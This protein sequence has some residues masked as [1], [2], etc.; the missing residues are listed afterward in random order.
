MVTKALRVMPAT[1]FS[2]IVQMTID[3]L[4]SRHSRRSYE[5]ALYDFLNWYASVQPD[6]LT[7]ATI[8]RYLAYMRDDQ[9]MAPPYINLRLVAIRRLVR[10][11][12]MN[13]LL[14]DATA[15]AIERIH[16]V[17]QEGKRLGNWLTQVQA[18][19]LLDMPDTS[20]VKGLRDRAILAVLIGCGLR[21]EEASH[22]DME[23]IQQRDNHWAIVDMIGKRRKV[24]TIP[25][26]PWTKTAIDRWTE[27][28][29]IISGAVF[30]S[31]DRGDHV[32]TARLSP[33]AIMDIVRS[34][35]QDL[36]VP[37]LAP[38]DLRRT[39]AKLAY[40]G[41]A[42][43]DQISLSLGHESIETT[44]RYLGIEQDFN[45]APCDALGLSLAA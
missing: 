17:P 2:P 10:E 13:G 30:H 19:E 43:L 18:Q 8:G 21:R 29:G 20:R 39:F 34:Y 7:R 26:A 27:R 33:Q 44:Q 35:A 3:G 15:I 31:M 36:G 37:G 1:P 38:H 32:T 14:S 41:K 40:K 6:G 28:A 9:E 22:L 5:R 12:A 24:R 11:A 25:M 23:Q 42:P 45:N 16:G 4:N